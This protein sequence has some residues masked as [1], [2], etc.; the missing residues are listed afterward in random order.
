M[1]IIISILLF[2]VCLA[3]AC[4]IP[5]VQSSPVATTSQADSNSVFSVPVYS[6]ASVRIIPC[7]QLAAHDYADIPDRILPELAPVIA[8]SSFSGNASTVARIALQDPCIQKMLREN[9]FI[10]G[11]DYYIPFH[12][13]PAPRLI[14]YIPGKPAERRI[15]AFVNESEARVSSLMVEYRFEPI[16]DRQ[17]FDPFTTNGWAGG[18]TCMRNRCSDVC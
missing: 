13:A 11:V 9:G 8:N 6:N 7:D 18:Y 17:D 5:S 2:F 16:R 3:A 14:V 4:T 15:S 12:G 10:L 1:R